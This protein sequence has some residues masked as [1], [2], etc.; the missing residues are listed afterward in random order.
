MVDE[1]MC[2]PGVSASQ[3]S[4]ARD[5]HGVHEDGVLRGQLAPVQ[6]QRGFGRSA[7]ASIEVRQARQP[8]ACAPAM[9]VPMSA[10]SIRFDRLDRRR[11]M[12]SNLVL[13]T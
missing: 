12:S 1:P 7:L 5:G 11:G 9:V 10:S 13:R 3:K 2:G 6:Q 8:S 4:S